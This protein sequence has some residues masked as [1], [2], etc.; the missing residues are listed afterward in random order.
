MLR[1]LA[2]LPEWRE[3]EACR[4]G[5]EALLGLWEKRKERRPYLFAIG[6]RFTRLKARL[7]WYDIL[8]VLDVLTQFPRLGEDPRLQEM[9]DI[10]R[11]KADED[12][13]FT[14]ESVWRAWKGWSFGEKRE[15]SPWLT[16]LVTR[17]LNGR[18]DD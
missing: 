3:G 16:L 10:V 11:A 5:A 2:Q 13:R 8:H 9:V 4:T 14:P 17:M 1:A 7:I 6:A 15:P 18:Y 12:G